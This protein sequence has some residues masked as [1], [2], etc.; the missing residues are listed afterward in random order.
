MDVS[1]NVNRIVRDV[2]NLAIARLLFVTAPAR[3]DH[4]HGLWQNIAP[5]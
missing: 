3:D 5:N 4:G 2:F 1:R